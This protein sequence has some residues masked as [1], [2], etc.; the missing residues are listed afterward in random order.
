M[1]IIR[2]SIEKP[3]S[4]IVGIILVVLFGWIGLQRM[5]YQLSPS[6][7]EA[8]ITVTT[9]WP[10]A[11]PYEI[12]RE[13]IEE[14]EKVLKG[15]PDLVEMESAS[16]NNQGTVTLKFSIGTDVNNALLRVSNKLD[17]VAEYPE[18]VEK[19]IISATGAAT[20]PVI[21]M[22]LKTTKENSQST[23]TYRT[24][25]ENN[26][27]QYLERTG[28]VADLFIG[29]G[30]EKEMH[31]V[32]KPE[33]LAAYGLTITDLI[34]ILRAENINISAGTLGLGRRDY[35]IRSVAE[36]KSPEDI[37]NIVIRSTGL[38]RIRVADLAE[39]SFG[40]EKL[41]SA[42][43]HVGQEGIAIGVKPEPDANIL[44][45]SDQ[46]EKVVNWLNTE[47]LAPLNIY[48]DWVYDQRPYIRGAISLVRKNI[49]LGGTLAI[50]VL[51]IFLRSIVSTIIV[52]DD[53]SDQYYRHLHFHEPSGP[54]SEYH[55]FSGH[56]LC[57]GNVD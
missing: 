29:G 13:I 18:N 27:R 51:L 53:N 44:E 20:S 8:E 47:K 10:G 25:F 21:W 46:L 11:T 4:V 17:E 31:V 49:M 40:H 50:I 45:L 26:I 14:Q 22:V 30:I 43:L 34:N 38:Q 28:G 32:V 56:C 36:F 2:F 19:P 35:R 39:V 42:M 24:Y 23:Y 12:E 5:P 33:R 52:A 15:I 16:F 55:Q 6:V 41:T 7:I 57:G 9:T 37:K 1:N 54:Q 3:V 48:L